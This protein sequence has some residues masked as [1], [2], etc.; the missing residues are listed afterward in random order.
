MVECI[1]IKNAEEGGIG[2]KEIVHVVDAASLLAS[3]AQKSAVVRNGIELEH[4]DEM[5]KNSTVTS[6]DKGSEGEVAATAVTSAPLLASEAERGSSPIMTSIGQ[7][8]MNMDGTEILITKEEVLRNIQGQLL[9]SMHNLCAMTWAATALRDSLRCSV[10]TIVSQLIV[11]LGKT[12]LEDCSGADLSNLAWALAKCSTEGTQPIPGCRVVATWI[13]EQ[14]YK[15]GGSMQDTVIERARHIQTKLQP[16]QLSRLLWSISCSLSDD[17]E[18]Y[19]DLEAP[20]KLALAGLLAAA[21]N[22]HFYRT[23]D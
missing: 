22:L 20:G 4:G 3:E 21:N 15:E 23:E 9:F 8:P 5:V 13:A 7:L 6:P 1:T 2:A 11:E 16:P 14:V 10:T 17:R 12:S 19:K 18:F